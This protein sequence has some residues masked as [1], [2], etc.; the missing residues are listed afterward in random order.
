MQPPAE[1]KII[2]VSGLYSGIG[3]TELCQQLV[4]L[5]PGCAAIKVTINDH[6]TEVLE[7]EASIMVAGKDTWRLKTNGA[8]HVV[9]VRAQEAD[10]K[11]A[12]ADALK[13]VGANPRLVIESNSVLGHISPTIAV[14]MCDSRICADKPPKP[15]R[16]EALTKADIIINNV[17]A[18]VD[19][20]QAAVQTTIRGYNPAAPVISLNIA[21]SATTAAFARNL[22][23]A[24]GF[25][26]ADTC[27]S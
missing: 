18:G 4:S 20:A 25:L 16:A 2:T 13:R 12:L 26:A 14:F 27:I 1:Q 6:T 15:S 8:A 23:Q 11:E 9:W 24:Y 19:T 10:L 7:E 17:R 21:D 22:L 5:M 3:K